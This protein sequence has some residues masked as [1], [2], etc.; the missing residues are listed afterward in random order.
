MS[1]IIK[2]FAVSDE[3]GEAGDM[4]YIKHSSSNFT[5]ID[6]CLVDETKNSIRAEITEAKKGKDIVRFISTHPDEDH[7]CGLKYL[8]DKI[9]LPNFY[10]VEND[11]I[12]ADPSESFVH[13]CKLRDDKDK[14]YY[15]YEGCKRKWMNDNDE[16]DGKNYG[17]SG[18][19]FL[20]PKTSNEDFKEAQS[21]AKE[22]KAYNNLSPIFTY[23]LNGNIKVMWMGDMEKDFQEKVKD[24]IVWPQ[25]DVLFAPHHGRDSG[26]VPDDVLKKLK[27][28]IIVIGEAPSKHLNYY[29]GYNTITQNSAGDIVFVCSEDKVHVYVSKDNYAYDTSFLSD[30]DEINSRYGNYLGSFTP[31]GAK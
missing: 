1:V 5:I 10:C 14:Y 26:K 2:S 6:C 15:V 28:Q 13:Y 25:V 24:K 27:P 29:S 12:K 22:G 17:S 18:I 11:A 9:G 30:E 20:W 4:F 23:T 8:D 16:N 31:K 21:Q 7:I 19:N 3:N